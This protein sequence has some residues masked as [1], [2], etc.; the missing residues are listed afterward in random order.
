MKRLV[1]VLLAANFAFAV[2]PTTQALG[3][4]TIPIKFYSKGL[5]SYPE[6]T[7]LDVN[8][9]QCDRC[10]GFHMDQ[11]KCIRD[12]RTE[13]ENQ[14]RYYN[15]EKTLCT[16]HKYACDGNR[17]KAETACRA[18]G[19]YRGS[20]DMSTPAL[21]YC[22][23][24]V[25]E[26][27]E[28]KT[29]RLC[30]RR[31]DQKKA[32]YLDS[33][34]DKLETRNSNSKERFASAQQEL[35]KMREDFSKEEA[36]IRAKKSALESD[37]RKINIDAQREIS[38][39]TNKNDSVQK[40][41]QEAQKIQEQMSQSAVTKTKI[42]SDYNKA[43]NAAKL[44]CAQQATES[45]KAWVGSQATKAATRT[46]SFQDWDSLL[47][48]EDASARWERLR[49]QCLNNE[50]A[51]NII[52]QALLDKQL[53]LA[54]MDEQLKNLS[55][56]LKLIS[57]AVQAEIDKAQGDAKLR[58]QAIQEEINSK[59]KEIQAVDQELTDLQARFSASMQRVTQTLEE[60]RVEK[61]KAQENSDSS[62][63]ELQALVKKGIYPGGSD[64]NPLLSETRSIL[65]EG[66]ACGPIV[67]TCDEI[68]KP[69]TTTAPATT[70]PAA[71]AGQGDSHIDDGLNGMTPD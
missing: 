55:K 29:N 60:A 44:S 68:T 22:A 47:N 11:G 35:E 41:L 32:T 6:C 70:T 33:K 48:R 12:A 21:N 58:L 26:C 24:M 45:T 10:S 57:G 52:Y 16:Q 2:I 64:A 53:S 71:P 66:A 30:L 1:F 20:Q 39:M 38:Q 61:L 51:K 40:A 34:Q 49:A 4:S 46:L 62:E 15:D 3:D 67:D 8:L 23:K 59:Q 54:A 28:D 42:E 37:V 43:V 18:L 19:V 7:S 36:S 65:M 31:Q 63:K 5:S 50:E 13:A 9:N 27:L 69:A 14:T 17:R 56:E 25:N